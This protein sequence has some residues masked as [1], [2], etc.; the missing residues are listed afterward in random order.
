MMAVP[1]APAHQKGTWD[2][3][4]GSRWMSL[5][6]SG[7][8][9]RVGIPCHKTPSAARATRTQCLEPQ[10]QQPTWIRLDRETH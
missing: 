9:W 4:H 7:R 10:Q 6:S 1:A 2:P 5:T 8:R 3:A